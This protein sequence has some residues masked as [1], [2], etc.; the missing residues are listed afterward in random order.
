MKLLLDQ[1][2]SRRLVTRLADIFPDSTHVSRVGLDRTSD[3]AVWA[4]AH[5][6]ECMIVTKDADFND[7]SILRGFPPKVIWLRIGNCTTDQIE[8]LLRRHRATI[9]TFAADPEA[10]SLSLPPP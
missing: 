2:L 10:G 6:E 7:L 5:A 3:Q 1:N 4:Y 8:V 9:T